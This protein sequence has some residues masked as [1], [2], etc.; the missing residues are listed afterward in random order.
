MTATQKSSSLCE[1]V[2]GA[3]HTVSEAYGMDGCWLPWQFDK[4]VITSGA[5]PFRITTNEYPRSLKDGVHKVCFEIE[6]DNDKPNLVKFIRFKELPSKRKFVVTQTS[7]NHLKDDTEADC[8]LWIEIPKGA[9]REGIA[10]VSSRLKANICCDQ[11]KHYIPQSPETEIER[12][13]L[14]IAQDD[15]DW[16][17]RQA[18]FKDNTNQN[19]SFALGSSISEIAALKEEVAKLNDEIAKA[20]FL[21]GRIDELK[22]ELKAEAKARDDIVDD[23]QA[24]LK[25]RD[26]HV[27]KLQVTLKDKTGTITKLRRDLKAKGTMQEE[28]GSDSPTPGTNKRK[29]LTA[30]KT[31]K[32]KSQ[33]SIISTAPGMYGSSSILSSGPLS[34]NL[35]ITPGG[36]I[37]AARTP[38][39][40]APCPQ[41]AESGGDSSVLLGRTRGE[42]ALFLSDGHTPTANNHRD[43]PSLIS[44]SSCSESD[45]KVFE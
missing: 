40:N 7:M 14:I 13:Q 27:E 39:P 38:L 45:G 44:I 42:T 10:G 3:L 15:R 35:T 43:V 11:W 32:G 20:A 36:T 4:H 26:V 18:I 37:V 12:D 5:T 17:K 22:A 19:L 34:Q 2:L 28:S 16:L 33:V 41:N 30:V 6:Y 9:E 23:L 21:K 8:S 31:P 29:R 24:K 1:T 25:S